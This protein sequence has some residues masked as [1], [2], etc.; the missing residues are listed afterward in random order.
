MARAK[1]WQAGSGWRWWALVGHKKNLSSGDHCDGC[2]VEWL[3]KRDKRAGRGSRG[4]KCGLGKACGR[5]DPLEQRMRG[6]GNE[7]KTMTRGC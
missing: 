4:G 1:P 3:G 6:E 2:H 5:L 7:C